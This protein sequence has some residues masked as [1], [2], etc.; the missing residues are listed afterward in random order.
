MLARRT[1]ELRM[2][3]F[4][5]KSCIRGN[6]VFRSIWNP[7]TGDELNCVQERANTEDPCLILLL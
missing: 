7:I 1:C 2:E 3:T 4:E 5:V 6:Q